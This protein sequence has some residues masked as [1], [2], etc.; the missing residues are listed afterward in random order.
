[1]TEF[2]CTVHSS[3]YNPKES[4]IRFNDLEVVAIAMVGN[5]GVSYRLERCHYTYQFVVIYI[6]IS[7]QVYS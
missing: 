2:N 1:M 3:L 7:L 5:Q 6:G 4:C